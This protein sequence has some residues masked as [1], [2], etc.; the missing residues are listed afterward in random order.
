MNSESLTN[1][2][3]MDNAPLTQDPLPVQNSVNIERVYFAENDE[4]FDRLTTRRRPS[5]Q[6]RGKRQELM[7]RAERK[8]KQYAELVTAGQA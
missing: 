1:S 8:F 5:K 7:N 2:L 4:G 6:E 3:P